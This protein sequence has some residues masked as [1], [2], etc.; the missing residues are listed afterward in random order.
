MDAGNNLLLYFLLLLVIRPCFCIDSLTQSQP[1]KDGDFLISQGEVFQ[2]GFFSRGKS[3]NRYVGVWY[4]KLSEKTVV[5][6]ANRDHPLTNTSGVLSVD[7]TGQLAL[8]YSGTPQ[9]LIWS[10]D[11]LSTG[12]GN[13]SAKILDTGN[14]VLFKDQYSEKNTVWQGFDHPTDTFLPYMKLQWNKR[15]RENKFLTSWKSPENPASGQYSFRFN[16]TGSVPQLY[17]YDGVTP[18]L[19]AGPWNGITFSGLPEYTVSPVNDVTNLFYIDNNEEVA[20]YYIVN[21]PGLFTR[22]VLN[23]EGFTERLNWNPESQKWDAFW[24]GPDGQC[25]KYAH[26]GAFSNCNPVKLSDQG[27]ECL[28]GYQDRSGGKSPTNIFGGCVRKPGALVCNNGEGFKEVPGV[29]VPD[30][31]KARWQSDLGIKACKEFCL[32]DCSCSACMTVNITSGKGCLTWYADLIDVR[33]FSQGGQ[34]LYLRVD[35]SE[36]A[37]DRTKRVLLKVLLPVLVTIILIIVLISRLLLKKK[38]I[39]AKNKNR[40][41]SHGSENSDI[42]FME[43]YQDALAANDTEV[44]CFSANT[45]IAA[46]ENFSISKKLGEGGFGPVYKVW[47]RWLQGKPLEIVDASLG[48]SYDVSEVSR[49][50]HIGLLCVQESAAIRPTMSEVA[51]MLCNERTPSSAPEQP[52]F[53]NRATVNFG[54]VKSCS[55]SGIAA[56]K[57]NSVTVSIVEGR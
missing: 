18:V 31:T 8:S 29:K 54:S 15:T 35:S 38:K 11:I 42:S 53:I 48:E 20:T 23:D 33:E 39:R 24:T 17:I 19:R 32:K 36:L 5:W 47:D 9:V 21:T 13:Y 27:C 30:A 14:F 6:V 1:L 22:F 4:Y 43:R 25:D 56:T 41:L 55:S 44:H 52:A 2:L 57:T 46:T 7:T 26:C 50:I 10:S 37:K 51:S 49:C 3:G 34:V 45:I 16:V 12:G 40:E 28:P